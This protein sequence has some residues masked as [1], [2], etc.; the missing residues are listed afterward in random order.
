MAR[1][2]PSPLYTSTVQLNGTTKRKL[3]ATNPNAASTTTRGPNATLT[4]A[5]NYYISPEATATAGTLNAVGTASGIGWGLVPNEQGVV[6]LATDGFTTQAATMAVTVRANRDNGITSA[7]QTATITAIFFRANAN[8]T[9]FYE[10]LGRASLA[11][12]TFTTTATDFTVNVPIAGTTFNPGDILWL[13]IFIES[14][15][16]SVTGSFATFT[17]NISTGTRTTAPI[18]YDRNYFKTLTDSM[19]VADSIARAYTGAR[20]LTD[21]MPVADAITRSAMFPRALTDTMPVADAITR[22]F[23]ANRQLNDSMPVVDS[24][25]RRFTGART[26]S[27]AVGVVDAITR[28]V[29]YARNIVDNL[30]QGGGNV[31]YIRSLFLSED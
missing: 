24:I 9:V 28:K 26:L 15:T 19:P 20:S 17:T 27:D 7:N 2:F 29:T 23:T 4:A 30:T 8:A 21:S 6:P 18:T 22:Q 3:T 10:E 5:A 11:G 13:E 1:A 25:A 14:T 16:T 31:T 12:Q